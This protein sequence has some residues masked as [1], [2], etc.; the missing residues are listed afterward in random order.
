MTKARG[1]T[2]SKQLEGVREAYSLGKFRMT[3]KRITG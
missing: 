2:G 1:V 3:A